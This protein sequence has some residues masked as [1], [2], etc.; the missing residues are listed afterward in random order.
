L[1]I[2][3]I[4]INRDGNGNGTVCYSVEHNMIRSENCM[5]P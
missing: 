2:I 1:I 4:R 3:K 5:D